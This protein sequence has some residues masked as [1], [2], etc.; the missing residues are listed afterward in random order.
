MW[1]SL[2]S[3]PALGAGGR[4]F[5]SYHPDQLRSHR[6]E[7]RMPAFHAGDRGSILLGTT[8]GAISSVG[9]ASRLHR[10]GRRF[11]PVIAHH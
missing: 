9:R 6:L 8:F 7:V 10:E 5:E 4:R 3:A 1:R 11:E 2:V